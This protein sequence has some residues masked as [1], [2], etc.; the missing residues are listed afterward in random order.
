[1]KHIQLFEQFINEDKMEVFLNTTIK[2]PKSGRDVKVSSLINDKENPL[3]KKLQQ[4]KA[5]IEGGSGDN[6][7]AEMK[8]AKEELKGFQKEY[9]EL[10]DDMKELR[11]EIVDHKNDIK[12]G[13]DEDMVD[14]AKGELEEKEGQLEEKQAELDRI[15][16]EIAEVKDWIKN[17]D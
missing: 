5:E 15:S 11:S 9:A 3:Y 7:N 16:D 4:K 17:P 14:M 13:D 12:D 1:M 6:D 2:N 8:E 10:A